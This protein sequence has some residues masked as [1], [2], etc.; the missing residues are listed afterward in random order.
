MDQRKHLLVHWIRLAD[1]KPA[2]N[3]QHKY[4]RLCGAVIPFDAFYCPN[5]GAAQESHVEPV[6]KEAGNTLQER[7]RRRRHAYLA[8]FLVSLTIFIVAFFWGSTASLSPQ[9]SRA[10]I[11]DLQNM[12]GTT[13]SAVTIFQ[14]NM[15]ICLFF[16]AP[17]L[18]DVFMA[19]VAYNTGLVLAALPVVNPL[20]PNSLVLFATT[21]VFPWTWMELSAY[22]L[23][24][25]TGLMIVVSAVRR[26]LGRDAKRYLL[27]LVVCVVLL[28]IG[29]IIEEQALILA[30]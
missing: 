5:C 4:C 18:G 3:F 8:L 30:G 15:T 2:G 22:S 7:L 26:T 20:A 14:N 9:Y 6:I 13:P 29:A 27:S 10:L 16:F 19:L 12:I 1:G 11:N 23:A 21:L 17:F 25:S 28:A 24:S